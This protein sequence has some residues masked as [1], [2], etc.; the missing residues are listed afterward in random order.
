MVD[1][2]DCKTGEN[3]DDW[4]CDLLYDFRDSERYYKHEN[5]HFLKPLII[6]NFPLFPPPL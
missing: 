1:D 4:W 5:E 3:K 2:K 6:H